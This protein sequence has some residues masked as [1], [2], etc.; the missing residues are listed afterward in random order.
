[1][2]IGS[3]VVW[4]AQCK[5]DL[6]AGQFVALLLADWFCF[7]ACIRRRGADF[8]CC[9]GLAVDLVSIGASRV[10]LFSLAKKVGVGV[11]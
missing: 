9:A 1:M 4:V 7:L 10:C 3:R 11:D 5:V 8:G 2:S 6:A